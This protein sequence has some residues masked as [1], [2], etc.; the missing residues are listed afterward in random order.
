MT[1]Q[2][3][4]TDFC[5][6]LGDTSLIHGQ[7]LGELCGH[8]P[9]LEEDIALTNI[10]LDLIGQARVMLSYAGSTEGQN[11][12]ED[13]LAF[14]RDGWNFRNVLMAELPNGDFGFT[15]GKVFFLS[16][17]MKHLYRL[18]TQSQD[19]T[20]KAFSGKSLK[21]VIYHAR[22]ASDWVIRL[23]DG[24]DE[25]HQRMQQAIN[26]LALY[27]DDLFETSDAEGW[28]VK[29]KVI[30]DLS[31]LQQVFMEEVNKVLSEAKLS[32]PSANSFLR[33]GGKQGK[34][35]EHLGH[36]LAEMQFLPRAYP[37]ARW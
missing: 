2:Q 23:G 7:R 28:L 4:L 21:E 11:R 18:L 26:D 10:S 22:H 9:I 32:L 34:H 16:I 17:Y 3:A 20:L 30:P 33:K 13:Q 37:D 5:L 24:T 12:N 29:E 8:A 14:H 6:Q 31:A 36:L 25:S 35:T 27:L 1:T 15:I 19:E